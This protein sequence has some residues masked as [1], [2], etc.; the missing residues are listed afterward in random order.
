MKNV[1]FKFLFPL[2]T[3]ILLVVLL[4]RQLG[5]IPPLGKLL[6]PFTGVI[7]NENDEL[8]NQTLGFSDRDFTV[9][10]DENRIPHILAKNEDDMHFAQG[11]VTSKDRL[12][13]MDFMSFAAAGRLSEILGEGY[14]P[15]DRLQRRMG[16]LS[17]AKSTLKFIESNPLTKKALDAY[18]AGVNAHIDQLNDKTLPF[19][20]KLMNYQP[21]PWTNLK[22]VLIMKYVGA[23]LTGYEE[24]ISASYM[25]AALGE[26]DFFALYPDARM[27]EDSL[28]VHLTDVM[29]QL[30]FSNQIDYSFLYK[31]PRVE[32][33]QFNPRL[34]SNAWAIGSEKSA[35]GN[36]ILCNDPHLNLT[37]PSIWYELQLKSNERNVYGYSI[38]GTPGVI[39]GFNEDIS[40]GVTN[41]TTDVRDWY[42]LDLKE[43]YSAYKMEGKWKPTKRIIETIK[44]LD[45]KMIYDTVYYSE[46]GPIVNSGSF[47]ESPTI[48]D[49]AL[50][51]VLH[52]PTNEFLAILMMNKSKDHSSFANAITHFEFPAQNF[53]YADSKGN[54][55]YKL[56][57]KFTKRTQRG[58]G[59]FILDGT[60]SDQLY[61]NYLASK[62]LPTTFNPASGY[63]YSANNNPWDTSSVNYVNGYYAELRADK[64]QSGLKACAKF[65]V[66][67]MKNM[68]RDNTNHFAELALP[69]LLSYLEK[70][71]T[72]YK[73]RLQN[74]DARYD[75]E[76]DLP[77]F[78]EDWLKE[79]EFQMWDEIYEFDQFLRYPDNIVL[80]DLLKN[81]PDSKF[82]DR[83][84]TDRR[85]DAKTIVQQSFNKIAAIHGKKKVLWK[86]RNRVNIMHLSQIAA[87]SKMDFSSGG[88][89]DALNAISGNWGPSM[90][91]I[92]EMG[93][94][95]KA[96]GTMAGGTS[97]NPASK[98]YS[99]FVKEWLEGN[100]HE[101]QLFYSAD[102]AKKNASVIWKS[103]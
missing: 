89:P 51:W 48:R 47:E 96:I 53:I 83:K 25:L 9:Y 66:E 67:D 34:G 62:M 71:Q 22:S 72:G 103:N 32:K 69:L 26:E 1:S 86:E 33:S 81:S 7:Q 44:V 17:S 39:I 45:S 5:V 61:P 95:P 63:V 84:D 70:D 99:S 97:G 65:K 14:V 20:Y 18:T 85:E 60:K 76:S 41:G 94:K 13:Q 23:M 102:E 37:F 73:N 3:V 55:S 68:Q 28:S 58:A 29:K 91:M 92:V 42:K 80:L 78:Y 57:G 79:F 38:P 98:Y 10:F 52:E 2:G 77:A 19:E 90:R 101:L 82:F 16:V 4:D 100:Y 35:S 40:W 30:P 27:T 59:K 21:E 12:W 56:Q 75:L 49:Y 11:F 93:V 50:K 54:I 8:K 43:D 15:H 87:L 88:H 24:D 74:W 6:N 64:I 36:A 31:N 46:Q